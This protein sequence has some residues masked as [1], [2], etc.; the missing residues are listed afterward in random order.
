MCYE[1]RPP[2]LQRPAQTIKTDSGAT[3]SMQTKGKKVRKPFEAGSKKLSPALVT[4][5]SPL[6]H[7]VQ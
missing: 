7:S 3:T 2:I 6:M 1:L 4:L 5:I